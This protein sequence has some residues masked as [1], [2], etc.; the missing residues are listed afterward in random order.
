MN[1]WI[2]ILEWFQETKERHTLI[3]G[4]NQSAKEAFVAGVMPVLI[5]A[6]Q[7]HGNPNNKHSFSHWLYS[8]FRIKVYSGQQLNK[9]DI[10]LLGQVVLGNPVLVRRLVVCGFDTLEVHCDTGNYGCQW[11]L[12]EY[13]QIGNQNESTNVAYDEK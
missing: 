12:K 3:M 13:M 1:F 7:S 2:K 11:R 10:I 8:G 6:R 9:Q 5:E 4:F